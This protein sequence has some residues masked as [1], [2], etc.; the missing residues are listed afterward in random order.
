MSIGSVNR[1]GI[2]CE[3]TMKRLCAFSFMLYSIFAITACGGGAEGSTP[4]PQPA[5]AVVKLSTG[6]SGSMPAGTTIIGYDVTVTLPDGVTVK[7]SSP[8]ETDDGVVAA[9][10]EG[11]GSI[12]I[13]TYTAATAS[14]HGRIRVQLANGNGMSAGEFC[15]I[16]CE[17]EAGADP[18]SSDFGVTKFYADGLDADNTTVDLTTQL[19][20]TAAVTVQ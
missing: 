19:S 6:V 17:L 13:A 1:L 15:T 9:T 16:T 12:V 5:S 18:F 8:P 4:V 14:D 7:S 10:G 20:V 2:K 11:S 3:S